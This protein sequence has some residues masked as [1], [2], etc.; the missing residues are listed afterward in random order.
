V[1]VVLAEVEGAGTVAEA[2][3]VAGDAEASTAAVDDGIAMVNP[4]A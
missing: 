1:V 2:S 4:A 3:T